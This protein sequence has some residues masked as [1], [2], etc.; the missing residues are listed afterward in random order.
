[1]AR[2]RGAFSNTLDPFG[3]SRGGLGRYNVTGDT[4]QSLAEYDAYVVAVA[5][6]NGQATDEDYLA[7]LQKMVDLETVGTKGRVTAENK[8]GDAVYSIGR[9]KI[10]GEVNAANTPAERTAALRRMMAYDQ[11]R[12]ATMTTG[13]EAYRSMADRVA[14]TRTDIR[15]S[16]YSE[17]VNK[18]NAGKASTSQLLALA[19][20]FKAEAGSDPDA[21]TW[22]QSIVTLTD[23]VADENLSDAYQSYQ[24]HRISG[25]SLLAKIDA[26]MSDLT[27]GSPS[28]KELERQ[29]EDLAESIRGTART[30]R[31]AVVNGQ[32]SAGQIGDAAF[33]DY[34][35]TEVAQATPGTAEETEANN[36]LMDYTFSVAED[37]LR[38]KVTKGQAPVSTL[39]SFYK[40][41][42]AKM[43]PNSER[44]RALTLTI[45]SLG[46]GGGGASGGGGGGGGGGAAG[47]GMAF[48][49]KQLFGDSTLYS[50]LGTS[51]EPPGFANLFKIDPSNPTAK[52]W[53]DTNVRQAVEAFSRG[54]RT[55]TYLEPNGTGHVLPFEPSMMAQFDSMNV[56]YARLGL[57]DATS[58]KSQQTWLSRV[59]TATKALNSRGGTYTMDLYQKVFGDLERAK[60]SALGGKRWAEYHNLV[61]EQSDLAG[62]ALNGGT[63]FVPTADQKARINRDLL[64]IAPY[65]PNPELPFYNLD[66]DHVLT[67][68]AQG[69]IKLEW[70]NVA[71][72]DGNRA[73]I[74]GTLDPN[75]GY[76]T[77]R[78][79]GTT[80]LEII[81][82]ADPASFRWSDEFQTN[83]PSYLET[84]A[85]SVIRTAGQDI[86]V[87]QPLLDGA[88]LP[89][90]VSHT[91]TP[92]SPA[93]TAGSPTKGASV[94]SPM[95]PGKSASVDPYTIGGTTVTLPVQS[96][97]TTV[98]NVVMRW[99]SLD[100]VHYVG[101]DQT[102]DAPRIVVTDADLQYDPAKKQWVKNGNPVTP[103]DV[104]KGA[105]IWG[106][107]G[108]KLGTGDGAAWGVGAPGRTMAT[109]TRRDT[110][111][112]DTRLS[113]QFTGGK[114]SGAMEFDTTDVGELRSYYFLDPA[115]EL[116][117]GR[118]LT[119]TSRQRSMDSNDEMARRAGEKVQATR[120]PL[121]TPAQTY[122]GPTTSLNAEW[123][124][125]LMP[126][127]VRPAPTTLLKPVSRGPVPGPLGQIVGVKPAPL[128]VLYPPP[129]PK[130]ELLYPLVKP[131]AKLTPLAKAAPLTP[132]AKPA[133]GRGPGGTGKSA[134]A[135]AADARNAKA[136][137]E[138]AAAEMEAGRVG[139]T[140]GGV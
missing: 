74:K 20:T 70:D 58:A 19:R 30:E 127:G 102:L 26:R 16:Q 64:T 68:I 56:A 29:R 83:I 110:G 78:V 116:Q 120:Y 112:L 91:G 55:W 76:I 48:Y 109:A 126:K 114:R 1:M 63:G 138:A 65:Q 85:P 94:G 137:A 25:A 49:S 71:D 12:L 57:S 3:G 97:S 88:T 39:I 40:T 101:Y 32:R 38:F 132:L 73:A 93:V 60:T 103:A 98:G 44:Y 86:E 43:D 123:A 2:R 84:T 125:E 92:S 4:I 35:R 133:L 62:W 24:H 100:G 75:A 122:R 15:Q 118:D 121:T 13:N 8:L 117:R 34:L 66:G 119:A 23:R 77:Q 90:F 96:F 106:L 111:E 81:D 139:Y 41:A 36:R 18:V 130:P 105:H 115:A 9:N 31:A 124:G 136:K 10:A 42:R 51:K 61:K 95:I 52:Q 135:V 99:V 131:L 59:V 17:L 87:R 37:Q 33:L 54:D 21:D 79:D 140:P 69:K 113:W 82:P 5:W 46:R 50:I 134:A 107:G 22:A 7:S 72:A 67:L 128:A 27:P 11:A 53:W 108:P 45:D 104:A 129:T 14:G 6:A 28:Y 47:K 89:V 80:A